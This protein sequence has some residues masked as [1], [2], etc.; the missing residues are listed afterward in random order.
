MKHTFGATLSRMGLVLA[1]AAS[2]AFMPVV[3]SAQEEVTLKMW[4]LVNENYPEFI[5]AAAAEFKKTH[6][7]V[8]IV[9][10]S[11][12]NEAYKT[13]IQV[14][15]TGSEPPDVFFNWSGEDA[16]RLARD[17]LVLDI[18]EL[19]AAE[20]NFKSQ[21]SEA[22]QAS[23]MLDGKNYG[24]PTDAV[25]KYFYYDKPFFAEHKLA[26]P[27]TFGELLGLCKA[28]RAI[29]P[30]MVPLPLGNSERWKL[31]HY[32]TVLNERVLGIDATAA[33]YALTAPADQLFTN[34]GYVTAWQKVLD[35]KDAGCFQD[36]PNA[37]SPEASRAMF[38]T[39]GSP[40]IFCGSWCMSTFDGEGYTDYALFRFPR[41]EDGASDGTTN[42]V[43]PQGLQIAAKTKHPEEAV[44]WV[45]FLVSPEMAVKFAEAR[46]ALPSNASKISELTSATEQFKWIATDMASL[47]ASF[48]V[49]DVMLNAAVANA[50]LDAGV[51]VL[52]GTKTPEQAM[53][54]IRAVA[55]E[56]KAKA[57]V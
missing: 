49:L 7:N 50:Y 23:F 35:L 3:A 40:M 46:G 41:L 6:P 19:G 33:D 36:A 21:I 8:S 44:A 54:L 2:L 22:W 1:S 16:A 53:E 12:P 48:N 28:V 5:E 37:T 57:G 32:I 30:N 9:L 56:E 51:E 38:S 18:T 15:L 43:I 26:V 25:T 10:E 17:G 55:L 14:A 31:N 52:N 20:G 42:M 34:P 13:A 4:A 27:T 29:D 45:S 47:S 24:V 11:T 39:G